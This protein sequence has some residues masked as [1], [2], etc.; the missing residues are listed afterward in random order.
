MEQIF[1]DRW[2]GGVSMVLAPALLLTG[3]LLR[4]RFHFFF[5]Q[6]LQA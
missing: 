3:V 5:P 4:I 2:V 1:P 6:Q